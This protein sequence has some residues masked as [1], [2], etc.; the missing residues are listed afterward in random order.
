MQWRMFCWLMALGIVCVA[1]GAMA[2]D[3]EEGFVSLFNGK[4]LT[5][6]DG[7]PDF[8]SV[9][10]GVIHGETTAEKPT[11]GNTFLIWRGGTLKDYELRLSFRIESGNSGVQHRSQ[12]LGEWHVSGYQAEVCNSPATVGFLYHERGRKHLAKVGEKVVIDENGKI[13]VVGKLGEAK[14]INADYKP[15][16]WNH[17]RIIAKGNRIMQYLNGKQTIDLVD[18]DPKGRA[19]EGILALQIHAGPPMVVE[20][21][22]IRLKELKE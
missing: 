1:V 6:W 3:D 7:N 20:F 11:K 16:D 10:D 2:A 19:L 12:D 21:K 5:G 8:W 18:N 22:D 15:K 13:E 4:D 9:K 14:E 17:Y